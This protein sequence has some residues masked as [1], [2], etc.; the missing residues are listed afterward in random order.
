RGAG[1]GNKQLQQD[2]Q[3]ATESLNEQVEQQLN[4]QGQSFSNAM[5]QAMKETKDMKESVKSLLSGMQAGSGKAELKKVPLRDQIQLADKIASDQKIKQIAD[6]AGRLKQIARQ[7]QKSKH[8]ETSDRSGVT[9]GNDINRLLPMELA[10][11]NHEA[12]KTD[13]FRKFVEGQTMQYETIGK[14][15]I[16]KGPIILCL[17]QSG[18]MS[19]L[20]T[21]SKGF[22]LAFMSIAKRQR[23]DF[24]LIP[25]STRTEVYQYPKGKIKSDDMIN[26]C[27]NFLGGG[28]DFKLPL[29]SSLRIINESSFKNSDI[30]FVTDGEDSLDTTF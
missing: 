11:Y 5:L 26:L 23:R 12:T 4:N 18:S 6:W 10:L 25:F 17:D 30:L 16:G 8:H 21:Q 13:F 22:A 19:G 15:T 20:D 14:E 9:L 3:Q 7:K 24:C 28:T 27:Q 2:I 29:E 1:Q